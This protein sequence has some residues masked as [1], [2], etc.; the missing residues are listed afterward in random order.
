MSKLLG[1]YGTTTLLHLGVRAI[2]LE[3]KLRELLL[4]DDRLSYEFIGKNRD[5]IF[6]TGCSL[7]EQE[8]PP[9]DHPFM[10]DGVMGR[11]Y[12]VTDLRKYIKK[13]D[14]KPIVLKDIIS[15]HSYAMFQINRAILLDIYLEDDGYKLYLAQDNLGIIFA[16]LIASAVNSIIKLNPKERLEVEGVCYM[17]VVAMFNKSYS[18]DDFSNYIKPLLRKAK[19]S[20]PVTVEIADN[21][22]STNILANTFMGCFENIQ[23]V[24]GEKSK[25]LQVKQLFNTLANV[26]YGPGTMETTLLSLEDISTM[27]ALYLTAYNDTSFKKSRL[28]TN[29][30]LVKRKL[31]K[32][33]FKKIELKIK[34]YGDM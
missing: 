19:L 10:I 8:L 21:V 22:M 18:R 9:F 31:D 32:E 26:W 1:F 24:L 12:I 3:K 15:N 11:K 16:N 25:A 33:A 7:E 23:R 28:S 27:L 14:D 2:E 5:L 4:R 30:E 6:I 13:V 34:E 29:I 17:Y 20:L